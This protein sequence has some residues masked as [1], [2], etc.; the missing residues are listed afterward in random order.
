[1]SKSIDK[2]RRKLY[3]RDKETLLNILYDL[4]S[5][6]YQSIKQSIG[7]D[8]SISISNLSIEC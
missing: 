7:K 2:T 6:P 4:Q 8:G 1:M 3:Y 5:W